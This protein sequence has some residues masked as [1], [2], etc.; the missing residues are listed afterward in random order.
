M[1]KST[2]DLCSDHSSITLLLDE[3]HIYAES[4][5]TLVGGI[6]PHG[7]FSPWRNG[8]ENLSR[9][10]VAKVESQP[11]RES[12]K[13]IMVARESPTMAVRLKLEK[14]LLSIALEG[15]ECQ[16]RD[17]LIVEPLGG[18]ELDLLIRPDYLLQTIRGADSDF[19]LE[20][21]ASNV[22]VSNDTF[23]GIISPVLPAVAPP[24]PSK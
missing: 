21:A 3:P 11:I 14:D 18:P 20:M 6:L 12:L 23:L 2:L 24:E 5:D 13:A 8:L 17:Q 19:Y 9:E 15:D 10:R 22:V 1:L 7:P 4:K 16:A